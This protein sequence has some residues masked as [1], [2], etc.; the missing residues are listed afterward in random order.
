LRGVFST[1]RL[2]EMTGLS[3]SGTAFPSLLDGLS[4]LISRENSKPRAHLLDFFAQGIVVRG[5]EYC[6]EVLRS[7]SFGFAIA[8]RRKFLRGV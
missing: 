1:G 6:T 2:R 3:R 4:V 7:R 5:V 8:C